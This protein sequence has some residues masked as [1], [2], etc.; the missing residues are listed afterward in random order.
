[1]RVST[2]MTN[3]ANVP[4]LVATMIDKPLVVFNMI[5]QQ[6]QSVQN[7]VSCKRFFFVQ[8]LLDLFLHVFVRVSVSC[9]EIIHRC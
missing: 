6:L 7:S 4:K 1:M 3:T 9:G 5:V 2:D 8:F